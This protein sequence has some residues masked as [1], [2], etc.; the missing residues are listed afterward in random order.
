MHVK[1]GIC[2]WGVQYKEIRRARKRERTSEGMFEEEIKELQRRD[3][4]ASSER[5]TRTEKQRERAGVHAGEATRECA[6][7]GGGLHT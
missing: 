3:K 5:E 4:R 7:M 2:L 6:R 1:C